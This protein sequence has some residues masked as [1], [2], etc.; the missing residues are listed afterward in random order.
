MDEMRLTGELVGRA[1][2][3]FSFCVCEIRCFVLIF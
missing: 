3:E 2:D 1:V